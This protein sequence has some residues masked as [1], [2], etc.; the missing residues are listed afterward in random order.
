[1]TINRCNK[2]KK[3]FWIISQVIKKLLEMSKHWEKG[4]VLFLLNKII[5]SLGIQLWI[6]DWKGK[7]VNVSIRPTRKTKEA[8]I[9][10][11][12]S[13]RD[14]HGNSGLLLLLL[15]RFSHVRLCATPETAAL[16]APPSLGFSRQG[17][18]SG[19]E[20]VGWVLTKSL[21]L[22]MGRIDMTSLETQRYHPMR[23]KGR[24]GEREKM[25][26][27][28][29]NHCLKSEQ[30]KKNELHNTVVTR[31]LFPSWVSKRAPK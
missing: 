10:G 15:S 8:E 22:K 18:W 16:Q 4:S 25:V 14:A 9:I 17:Q 12:W 28:L 2:C 20:T 29:W 31:I 11:L 24:N 27:I 26:L 3:Q 1:M 13:N 23:Q 6:W 19:L 30:E 7:R 5:F 21:Y